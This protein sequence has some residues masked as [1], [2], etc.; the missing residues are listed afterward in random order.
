MILNKLNNQRVLVFPFIE[1][2]DLPKDRE[3]QNCNLTNVNK[4]TETNNFNLPKVAKMT[5][6]IYLT[7]VS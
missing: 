3:N 5:A 1:M 4:V 6:A 7:K 2:H